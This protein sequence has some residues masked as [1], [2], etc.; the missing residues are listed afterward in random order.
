VDSPSLGIAFQSASHA[1]AQGGP[2]A[3]VTLPSVLT[4]LEWCAAQRWD[5]KMKDPGHVESL[6][7]ALVRIG[8]PSTA[9]PALHSVVD[10]TDKID[11]ARMSGPSYRERIAW[12]VAAAHA[13]I[14]A[15][16][17]PAFAQLLASL[18][19]EERLSGAFAAVLFGATPLLGAEASAVLPQL[20]AYMKARVEQLDSDLRAAQGRGKHP[21]DALSWT[22]VALGQLREGGR[23]LVEKLRA[24]AAAGSTHLAPVL[25]LAIEGRSA[26]QIEGVWR[27]SGNR[28]C[29]RARGVASS[30]HSVCGG[31]PKTCLTKSASRR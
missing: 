25:A 8:A 24:R 20:E 21:Y 11:D 2:R 30:L 1:L 19:T 7:M 14:D 6:L 13:Q 23:A 10:Q 3:K 27:G 9:A 5:G 4:A 18:S 15:R 28:N 31:R 16:A 29:V 22:F 12:L 17:V 26:P